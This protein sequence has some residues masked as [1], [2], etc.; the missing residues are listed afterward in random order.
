MSFHGGLTGCIL[1]MILFA[2]SRG[3]SVFSLFDVI[4]P[5]ATIG[6][7]L[8]RVANFINQELFGKPT[9]APWGVIFP[10]T[11]D[12][13]PRHPSQLYEGILEGL[14][15]FVVLRFFTHTQNR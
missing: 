10:V 6:L 5:S 1:A 12:G 15:L 11:G 14:V 13:I 8:G 3:F 4:G 2:R 7:F 9:D